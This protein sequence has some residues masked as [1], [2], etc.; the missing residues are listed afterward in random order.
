MGCHAGLSVSDVQLGF[1]APDWAQTFA[2]GDNQWLAH[3]TY[4]YG[5]DEIVAYSERLAELSRAM[6]VTTFWAGR[7]R[8]PRSDRRWLLAKQDYLATTFTLTPYDEKILQSWTYYGLPMYEI[9]ERL[10]G[11]QHPIGGVHDAAP[12]V[13]HVA[14]DDNPV[15]VRDADD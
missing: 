10:V 14:S 12:D 8:R 15:A 1:T 9:G 4:G 2:K 3:T 5:D 11:R 6:S 13:V 7:T